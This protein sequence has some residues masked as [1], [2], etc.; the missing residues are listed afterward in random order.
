MHGN[1]AEWV[2]DCWHDSY[3]G[4]P[5][6]GSAW[7]GHQCSRH[8]RRDVSFADVYRPSFRIAQRWY[9]DANERDRLLGFRVARTLEQ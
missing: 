7:E 5:T 9:D 6:D 8:V 3:R 4:A 1:V 2:Q